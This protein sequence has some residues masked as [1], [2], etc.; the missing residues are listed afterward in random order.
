MTVPPFRTLF[1]LVQQFF[2]FGVVGVVGFTMD[3]C[4]TMLLCGVVTLKIAA[5]LAYGIAASGTWL[6]NRLWTFRR[7][8]QTCYNSAKQW[9]RFL[10]ANL[11]GFVLNRG[12]VFLALS[13]IPLT[14]EWP[15]IALLCG[16][17]CGMFVNFTLCRKFVFSSKTTSLSHTNTPNSI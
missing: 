1:T 6:L 7:E 5:L 12:A 8:N 14:Q 10:L 4:S 11:P 3:W 15:V 13:L 9:G 17:L 16:T 2:Q